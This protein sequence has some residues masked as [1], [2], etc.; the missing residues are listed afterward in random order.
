MHE[1]EHNATNNLIML[2]S[3]LR[4]TKQIENTS[5]IN[6]EFTEFIT[7]TDYYKRNVSNDTISSQNF[8]SNY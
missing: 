8:I 6:N 5:E 3:T 1:R 7:I 4:S 2:S